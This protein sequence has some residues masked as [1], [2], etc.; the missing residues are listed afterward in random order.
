MM[1]RVSKTDYYLNIAEK[2]A[3][4]STCL[5]KHWGAVIVKDD[6]IISTGFNGAPRHVKDC[7]EKG[8]CRLSEYRRKHSLGRGTAYEQCLSAHAEMNA[9]IF[10][11]KENMNGAT[12]YL[13]GVERLGLEDIWSYV[14]N[15]NPCPQ[16]KKLIIN[17]G[18]KDVIVKIGD[19]I[20]AYFDVSD[21]DEEDIVGG[22]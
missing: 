4:R 18:I 21:W 6:V 3:E 7:L 22:Y 1:E 8:Y 15:P 19:K 2:V 14:A 12:L 17:A 11:D 13:C 9:M 10:G 16:C 5:N 20:S